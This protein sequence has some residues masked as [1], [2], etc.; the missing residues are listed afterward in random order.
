MLSD[1]IKDAAEALAAERNAPLEEAARKKFAK[2]PI[3]K[4]RD[5]IVYLANCILHNLK[6]VREGSAPNALGAFT[7]DSLARIL[8]TR[9]WLEFEGWSADDNVD[10]DNPEPIDMDL[11]DVVV[12]A[13]VVAWTDEYDEWCKLARALRTYLYEAATFAKSLNSTAARLYM[14]AWLTLKSDS[15]RAE[16]YYYNLCPP[17]EALKVVRLLRVAE[18]RLCVDAALAALP[19]F[20]PAKPS[21]KPRKSRSA[22]R[23]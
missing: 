22:K 19:K 12:R 9:T 13:P 7:I 2:G 15:Q 20:K 6:S 16:L 5:E 4:L 11:E 8:S 17:E 10:M 18:E 1:E 21:A 3:P 23:G 14:R